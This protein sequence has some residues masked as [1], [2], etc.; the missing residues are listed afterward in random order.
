M[1]KNG[2]ENTVPHKLRFGPKPDPA[3]KNGP[4]P[5]LSVSDQDLVLNEQT[6]SLINDSNSLLRILY[7][8]PI[9]SL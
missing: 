5:D 4:D 6:R 3:P 8:L 9:L 1:W 2:K 7:V